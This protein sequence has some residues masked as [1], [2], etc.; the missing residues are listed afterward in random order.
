MDGGPPDL[1]DK[2]AET[3]GCQKKTDMAAETRRTAVPVVAD[4]KAS[5]DGCLAA[6][7]AGVVREMMPGIVA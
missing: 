2:A 7:K 5:H 3:F 4:E 6:E 1:A